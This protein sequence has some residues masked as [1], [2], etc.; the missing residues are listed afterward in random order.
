MI[1]RGETI[2]SSHEVQKLIKTMVEIHEIIRQLD[3]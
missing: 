3:N 1:L 2:V